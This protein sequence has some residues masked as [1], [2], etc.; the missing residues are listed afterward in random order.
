MNLLLRNAKRE[1]LNSLINI[2]GMTIA[3]TASI[4]IIFYVIN[5]FRFDRF[6]EKERD[7]YRLDYDV[8]IAE[9]KVYTFNLHDHK[10][11][12][13]IKSDIP[14]VIH[15]STY[16]IGWQSLIKYGQNVYSERLAIV[17][18]DFLKMFTFPVIAGDNSELLDSPDEV[19]ITKRLAEKL[20]STEEQRFRE[21]IGKPVE[22]LNARDKVF[23]IAA[24]ID[25][26]PANSSLQFDA[27][28]NFENQD[29]FS[30]SNNN[31]GNSFL[32]VELLSESDVENTGKNIARLTR[33]Y[34]ENI[35]SDMQS[36]GSI[37]NIPD[38][39]KAA[40]LPFSD[41]YFNPRGSG[42]YEGSKK[43]FSVILSFIGFII[44]ATAVINFFLLSSGQ[45]IKRMKLMGVLKV[46]GGSG[47]NI[48]FIFWFEIFLLALVSILLAL[49]IGNLCLHQFGQLLQRNIGT[50]KHYL[51]IVVSLLTIISIF[52]TTLITIP[53]YM[54]IRKHKAFL[55]LKEKSENK[56]N[57]FLNSAFI[58]LQYSL[59]TVLII[60]S[61]VIFKQTQFLK[62]EPTG[63]DS[64]NM[65]ELSI[66][67]DITDDQ[68]F[69]LKR[70]LLKYPEI[71]SITGIDKGYEWRRSVRRVK[72]DNGDTYHIRMLRVDNDY[73][74][75]MGLSLVAGDD[76]TAD[77]L[78]SGN[79][80]VI[81]NEEFFRTMSMEQRAGSIADITTMGEKHIKGVVKDYHFDVM[82]ESIKPLILMPNSDYEKLSYLHIKYQEGANEKTIER[83]Q[84]I[85]NSFFPGREMKYSFF[86]EVLSGRYGHE[87]RWGY[88]MGI[89]SFIAVLIS[90]LGLFGLTHLMVNRKVK[91]IGIRKVNGA[92]ISD[93]I[94]QLN[95]Y[96]VVMI[97]ASFLVG[98]TVAYFIMRKWL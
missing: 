57:A 77:N 35:I 3:F 13:R 30:Q 89:A 69:A 7:I 64:E 22:F 46:F 54:N 23:R 81:V 49:L 38:C 41:V 88:I 16:R 73:I 17:N 93:I 85:W 72:N 25:D 36:D 14:Q 59:A 33:E 2:S 50:A 87:E 11:A 51:P 96:Y 34:Y 76:F 40:L 70:E 74:K 60:S 18:T 98:A 8:A 42:Y 90:S 82:S 62:K 86:D 32:F 68:T 28:I 29:Y 92:R 20:F 56:A 94:Y 31:Y 5:E 10:L 83:M 24:I 44:L 95:S 67:S 58:A 53:V 91:E 47:S 63:M 43:S 19:I 6:H 66:P 15:A 12:G 84:G 75:T 1:K 39:F 61:I 9:D 71:K 21:F 97:V 4:L 26:V 45:T 27:L 48:T 37:M 65:I 78:S 52:T 55:L 79:S 80:E